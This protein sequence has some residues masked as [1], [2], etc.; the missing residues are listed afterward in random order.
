MTLSCDMKH[1]KVT[2]KFIVMFIV[3]MVVM[4]IILLFVCQDIHDKVMNC[5]F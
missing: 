3:I 1:K 4:A 2:L 5:F